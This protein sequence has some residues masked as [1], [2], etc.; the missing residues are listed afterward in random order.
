[1]LPS[2]VLAH[3][4]R[5]RGL[6]VSLLFSFSLS[7][8]GYGVPPC[9]SLLLMS[10]CFLSTC[11]LQ[12]FSQ[13]S[14]T[15]SLMTNVTAP[16]RCGVSALFHSHT[17]THSRIRM[18]QF[19]CYGTSHLRIWWRHMKQS[20]RFRSHPSAFLFVVT[21]RPVHNRPFKDN[22]KFY[23]NGRMRPCWWLLEAGG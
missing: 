16:C 20:V 19:K 10:F 21:D 9:L 17:L 6:H 12:L 15:K 1:M 7:L 8:F 23:R 14:V 11:L 13:L 5:S 22:I 4:S 2:S 3:L 18:R